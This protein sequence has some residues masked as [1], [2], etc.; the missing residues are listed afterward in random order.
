MEEL[1]H[2]YEGLLTGAVDDRAT[3][4]EE[5]RNLLV[6]VASSQVKAPRR[7]DVEEDEEDDDEDEDESGQSDND[8]NLF[9]N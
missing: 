7:V 6:A 3:A 9:D 1:G 8:W 5:D 2:E 4:N